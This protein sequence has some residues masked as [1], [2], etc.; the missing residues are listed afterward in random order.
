MV[1]S[2]FILMSHGII[3][4][5]THDKRMEIKNRSNNPTGALM[6]LQP[7]NPKSSI[8]GW[9]ARSTACQVALCSVVSSVLV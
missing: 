4:T 8:K 2:A 9:H 1:D 3:A 5:G 7:A 6:T